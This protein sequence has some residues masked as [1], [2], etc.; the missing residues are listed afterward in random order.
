LPSGVVIA[1]K[2]GL[3]RII[4]RPGTLVLPDTAISRACVSFRYC[5][6][7][8]ERT[9]PSPCAR[10]SARSFSSPTAKVDGS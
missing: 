1:S 8:A 4:T 3:A 9:N 5:S 10:W 2:V 6:S 7:A